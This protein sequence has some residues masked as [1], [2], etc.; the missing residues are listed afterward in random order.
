V[1]VK[2]NANYYAVQRM[3]MARFVSACKEMTARTSHPNELL[4]FT[5][6][7]IRKFPHITFYDLCRA[8]VDFDLEPER[9]SA[10]NGESITW[11]QKSNSVK[12]SR[13]L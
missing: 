7:G 2:A 4:A 9:D 11:S 13:K 1:L 10:L 5:R 12:S 6:T 8:L 3:F